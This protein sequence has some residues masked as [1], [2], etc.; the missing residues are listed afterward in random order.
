MCFS[1]KKRKEK[2]KEKKI[3]KIVDIKAIAEKKKEHVDLIFND[4]E[5]RCSKYE[6]ELI[7][8][9]KDFQ[10]QDKEARAKIAQFGRNLETERL[11][12]RANMSKEK[13]EQCERM[14]PLFTQ[15][16]DVLSTVKVNVDILFDFGSYQIIDDLIDDAT[17][18]LAD[19]LNQTDDIFQITEALSQLTKTLEARKG[20]LIKAA[21][22]A[23]ANSK[24]EAEITDK[25]IGKYSAD[26]A[27][28]GDYFT[29]PANSDND[30]E[31]VMP[32]KHEVKNDADNNNENS[33]AANR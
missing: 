2:E 23:K 5:A 29:A 24:K 31:V 21:Q 9:E 25:Q 20:T 26:S 11:A 10:A 16:L 15:M 8:R 1:A 22:D 33:A 4:S 12:R 18:A 28:F 27:E 3:G 7:Q 32:V 6:D 14:L 13:L 19:G 17:L 30:T